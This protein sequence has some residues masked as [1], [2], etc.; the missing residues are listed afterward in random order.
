MKMIYN[1]IHKKNEIITSVTSFDDYNKA[2]RVLKNE[3]ESFRRIYP[4]GE[5]AEN[6]EAY[7][8]LVDAEDDPIES[9][10][11]DYDRFRIV[12]WSSVLK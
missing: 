9:F 11:F 6:E 7:Q 3:I 10:S 12:F 1:I 2:L 4:E 5:T 8:E